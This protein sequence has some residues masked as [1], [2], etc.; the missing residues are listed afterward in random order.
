M[1]PAVHLAR[2]RLDGCLVGFH[3]PKQQTALFLVFTYGLA[4]APHHARYSRAP[5]SKVTSDPRGTHGLLRI[6]HQRENE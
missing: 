1:A 6:E 5:H 4:N 2:A 3:Q